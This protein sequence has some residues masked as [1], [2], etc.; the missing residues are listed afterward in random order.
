[1]CLV[2]EENEEPIELQRGMGQPQ[3]VVSTNSLVCASYLILEV[4]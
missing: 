1:M 4:V 3:H 2:W